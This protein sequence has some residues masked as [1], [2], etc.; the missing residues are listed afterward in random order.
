VTNLGEI[1]KQLDSAILDINNQYTELPEGIYRLYVLPRD[2]DG[3]TGQGK[4]IL[5]TIGT[6]NPIVTLSKPYNKRPYTGKITNKQKTEF[7]GLISSDTLLKSELF[8]N[9]ELSKQFNEKSFN[10]YPEL[11]NGLNQFVLET[12]T[13]E[14]DTTIIHGDVT[15]DIEGPDPI[16]NIE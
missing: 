6:N 13:T 11:Q 14:G 5:F 3:Q 12:T 4:N 16:I 15:L 1:T 7:E 2:I 10:I 9:S 8:I